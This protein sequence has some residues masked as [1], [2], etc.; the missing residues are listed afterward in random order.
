M[1]TDDPPPSDAPKTALAA[2]DLQRLRRL[3]DSLTPEGRRRLRDLAGMTAQTPRSD[4]IGPEKPQP[5]QTPATPMQT[6][7]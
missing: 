2:A 3:A 1:D 7:H 6:K 5:E 4:R